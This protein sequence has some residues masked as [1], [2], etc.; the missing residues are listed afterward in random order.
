MMKLEALKKGM[1]IN[2][3]N[4]RAIVI[5]SWSKKYPDC[6]QI[7]Y[8]VTAQRTWVLRGDEQGLNL[9]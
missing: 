3:F 8:S 7:Q 4:K 6:V 5:K 1:M 9:A 2:V